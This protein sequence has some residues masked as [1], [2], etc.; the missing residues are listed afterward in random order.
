MDDP[1]RD[2][3]LNVTDGGAGTWLEWRGELDVASVPA[4]VTTC[5]S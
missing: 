2:L 5:R 4:S 1:W 3:R